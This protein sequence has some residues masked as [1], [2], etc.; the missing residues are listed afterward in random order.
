TKDGT[1]QPCPSP[2]R[3]V[4][5][6]HSLNP[7][8]TTPGTVVHMKADVFRAIGEP[9]DGLVTV[10]AG[11]TMFELQKALKDRHGLQIAGTP[12]I[13]NATAGSVACCG[14]KDASLRGRRGQISSRVVG[15]K[16]ID[17]H[18]DNREVTET[19]DP[20]RMRVIRSSYGLLGI[21]HAVT[22]ATC[23]LQT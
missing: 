19:A 5:S 15:V 17:A 18:G 11:V 14:T 22:F 12:E 20:D 7:C 9:V 10:G 8:F 13:G 4:G 16:M 6:L 21:I 2:V 23:A 3:A 1:R